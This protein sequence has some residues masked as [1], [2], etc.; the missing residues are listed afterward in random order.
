MQVRDRKCDA[1]RSRLRNAAKEI[2]M[3]TLV[4]V[5]FAFV[6]T[7]LLLVALVMAL[8]I[9]ALRMLAGSAR[10]ATEEQRTGAESI[11]H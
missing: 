4:Q 1:G 11:R 2:H 10:Q 8:P 5:L 3:R 6:V 9:Q 7:A